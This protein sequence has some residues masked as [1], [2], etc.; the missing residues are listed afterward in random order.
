VRVSPEIKKLLKQIS[1]GEDSVLELKNIEYK[2]NT[3]S[4][5][6]KNSMADEMAAMANSHGGVIILGVDDKSHEITG[7]PL[8]KL[9]ITETLICTIANDLVK[10]PLE[11]RIK[12]ISVSTANKTAKNIIRIDIPKSIFV[13]RSHEGYFYRIGSSKR[14]MSPIFWQGCFS[15]EPKAG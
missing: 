11:C 6:H 7:L 4:G 10:P 13:H 2:G 8:E 15:N 5:P 12:K 14:K 1:L 3:I 9:D